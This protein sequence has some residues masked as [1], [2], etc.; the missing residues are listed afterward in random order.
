MVNH[1]TNTLE[2][3]N[4]VQLQTDILILTCNRFNNKYNKFS[5]RLYVMFIKWCISKKWLSMCRACHI[6]VCLFFWL[7]NC[8]ERGW[9]KVPHFRSHFAFKFT[10]FKE[11]Y[12]KHFLLNTSMQT[13]FSETRREVQLMRS[14]K[15]A[16]L[17]SH[18]RLQTLS[19]L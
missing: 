16:S 1:T 19:S 13:A 2:Q 18:T 17:P 10:C 11:R 8:M 9:H 5:K 3:L 12:C 7:S 4:F 14:L 6:D 15:F